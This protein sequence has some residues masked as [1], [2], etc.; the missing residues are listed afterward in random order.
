M[1]DVVS[2]LKLFFFVGNTGA[3]CQ[4]QPTTA[5]QMLSTPVAY[6]RYI[7]QY[8]TKYIRAIEHKSCITEYLLYIIIHVSLPA[9]TH[10]C[11]K[12]QS[13]LSTNHLTGEYLVARYKSIYIL[14]DRRMQ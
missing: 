8:H 7:E 5:R 10:K 9:Y 6:G 2:M 3:N 13:S 4:P 14:L 12:N 11:S 1:Y